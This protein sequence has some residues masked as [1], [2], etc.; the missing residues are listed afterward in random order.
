LL[1][2]LKYDE[3]NDFGIFDEFC[4]WYDEYIIKKEEKSI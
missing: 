1:K 2:R 3:L 4:Y